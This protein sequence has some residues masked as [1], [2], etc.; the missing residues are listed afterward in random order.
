MERR[1]ARDTVLLISYA[2]SPGSIAAA[3]ASSRRRGLLRCNEERRKKRNRPVCLRRPGVMLSAHSAFNLG[4]RM[5]SR[6]AQTLASASHSH[7]SRL[8]W[9]ELQNKLQAYS[10]FERAAYQLSPTWRREDPL[11]QIIAQAARIHTRKAD[12]REPD[13]CESVWATEG[14]G[15]RYATRCLSASHPP[16]AML[17]A[18]ATDNVPLSSLVPLHAGTGLALAERL[19]PLI[20]KNP[21]QGLLA[22]ERLCSTNAYPGYFGVLFE[23]LGLYVRN[24]YPELIPSIDPLLA[25]HDTELLA[26]FWHGTGRGLY[27]SP[28]TLPPWCAAPWRGL[29]IA[30]L[31][32]PHM[33]ARANSISGYCWA[34]TLVNIRHPDILAAFLQHHAGKL[35]AAAL[36]DEACRNGICSALIIWCCACSPRSLDPLL[37]YQPPPAIRLFWQKYIQ[38]TCEIA[39]SHYRALQLKGSLGDLFRFRPLP[40]AGTQ[41]LTLRGR[42]C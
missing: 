42:A 8:V 11:A 41:D 21:R 32:A 38:Q 23:A 30:S 3:S 14:A 28:M 31:Q 15:H 7:E 5:L 27:F 39:L 19:L 22:F 16:N 12:A 18:T 4:L 17:G 10:L 1:M 35:A 20:E 26:L 33:L 29:G 40:E 2:G 13:T 36:D 6:S 25:H 34:L 9:Q 24:L 37:C